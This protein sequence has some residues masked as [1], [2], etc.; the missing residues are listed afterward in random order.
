MAEVTLQHG[1]KRFACARAARGHLYRSCHQ[2]ADESC[3]RIG[4]G[5]GHFAQDV[6]FGKNSGYAIAGIDHGHRSYVVIK[7]F[8]DGVRNCRIQRDG[9]DFAVAKFQQA[10]VN[11]LRFSTN[12]PEPML[13][14]NR[15]RGFLHYAPAKNEVK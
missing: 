4:S 15:N 2:F 7:H 5:H 1:G 6:S 8:V 11:L 3:F 12:A 9:R 14:P 10:H 13:H